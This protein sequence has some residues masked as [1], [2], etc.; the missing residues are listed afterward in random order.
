MIQATKLLFLYTAITTLLA[1]LLPTSV[2]SNPVCHTLKYAGANAWEPI[3]FTDDEDK[4]QGL[5]YDIMLEV[6]SPLNIK[7]L[8]TD[9]R[10]WRRVIADLKKGSIDALFGA[11]YN[12]ERAKLF[13]YSAPVMKGR[14]KLFVHVNNQFTFNSLNDLLDK[15]GVRP[16][17]GSY[18][19]EFDTFAN[20]SLQFSQIKS[21][22][23]MMKMVEKGRV[24]YMVLA[25][26]DGIASVKKLQLS[27]IIIPLEQDAA[28]LDVYI[29]F[30][31]TSLCLQKLPLINTRLNKLKQNGTITKLY[32][33][34]LQGIQ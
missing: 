20:Q 24:D 13:I 22:A 23:L 30:S 26:F 1:L 14:I 17:G 15:R 27:D 32:R 3:S 19:D 9:K 28:K 21:E 10:P 5:I 8:S 7:L 4:Y 25:E 33:Y 12:Q 11:Y 16:F 34:Y 2:L 18:G 6:L 29:L 31:K